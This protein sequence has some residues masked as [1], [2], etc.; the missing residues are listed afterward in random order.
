MVRD[1]FTIATWLSIGAVIQSTAY[2]LLPYRNIV[3]ILPVVLFLSYKLARTLAITAGLLPNP[4]MKDVIPN[5]TTLLFPDEKGVRE[6]AANNTMC[7]IILAVTS[8]HPL[9]AL[10]P[11]F[12]EVGDRFDNMCKE[13]GET[14]TQN[15]FLGYSSWL[16]AGDNMTSSEFMS[17]LYF[18]NEH[19]LHDYAHGPMHSE[20]LQWW[21]E[22]EK[23]IPH[24]G[25]MHEVFAC[26]KK[27]WEGIYVN[28]PPVGLG[29]TSKEVTGPDG[30]K[31]WVNP[32]VKLG[33]K[34]LYSKGRMGRAYG[35]DEWSTMASL[36]PAEL[37]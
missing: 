36:Q 1:Q 19:Y 14:A 3:T 25:I 23:K 16:N 8:N 30:K 9:G 37:N 11:G 22:T 7:A 5:R 20:A 31:S 24:I 33:G 12:K 29:A 34:L 27:S 21:R 6:Q 32:L 4:R 35:N 28:Y 17:I 10:G 26:P 13:L 2:A 15:G 18:E